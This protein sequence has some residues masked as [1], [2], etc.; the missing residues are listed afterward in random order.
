MLVYKFRKSQDKV[1]RSEDYQFS[2]DID[3]IHAAYNK[4]D[5]DDK[6]QRKEVPD[7]HLADKLLSVCLVAAIRQVIFDAKHDRIAG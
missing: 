3:S 1:Y 7:N 5:N 4:S 6:N 2:E